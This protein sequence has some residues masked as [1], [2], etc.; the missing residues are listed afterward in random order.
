MQVALQGGNAVTLTK[1]MPIGQIVQE[2]PQTV[3]VFL[4]H[5]LMCFGCAV[6]RFEN[7]EQGARAHGIDADALLA[8]LNEVILE[9]EEN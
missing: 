4:K 8:D 3:P 9:P 7:L 6:A 2:F 1:D 5:G